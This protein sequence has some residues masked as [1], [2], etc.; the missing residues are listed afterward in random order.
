MGLAGQANGSKTAAAVA[1]AVAV[2][3]AVVVD[4]MTTVEQCNS[5]QDYMK[6]NTAESNFRNSFLEKKHLFLVFISEENIF[7][8]PYVF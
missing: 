6:G 8:R 3:G 7:Y 2:A 4:I 1:V 5:K